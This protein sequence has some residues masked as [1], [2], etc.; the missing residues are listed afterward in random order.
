VFYKEENM[1]GELP[2]NTAKTPEGFTAKSRTVLEDSPPAMTPEEYIQ[3]PRQKQEAVMRKEILEQMM[4]DIEISGFFKP[5]K[6]PYLA[7]IIT[8][9]EGDNGDPFSYEDCLFYEEK[10]AMKID[11]EQKVSR[12]MIECMTEKGLT[13]KEPHNIVPL[14]YYMNYFA[15]NRKYKLL[16]LKARG[17]KK[18]EIVNAGGKLDCKAIERHKGV[19]PIGKVPALPL[20]CCDAVYCR[21]EYV[22]HDS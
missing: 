19:F 16:E 11:P 18:V 7:E 12:E 6:I 5:E 3:L 17:V 14:I 1:A 15:V 8:K 22:A 13:W 21:C 20:D 9:V 10:V 2:E 4:R